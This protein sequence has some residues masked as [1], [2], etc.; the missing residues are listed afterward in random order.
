[1]HITFVLVDS[2]S[3]VDLHGFCD[4]SERGYRAIVY[5]RAVS[6]GEALA[7][8]SIVELKVAPLKSLSLLR[9]EPCAAL[10]FSK[11]LQHLME[12]LNPRCVR[13]HPCIIGLHG[14]LGLD[15]LVT[16]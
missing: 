11:L 13:C 12:V 15:P 2:T 6:S 7:Q 3:R 10:L 1:M 16:N 9:L 5:L 14:H 8:S 4:A